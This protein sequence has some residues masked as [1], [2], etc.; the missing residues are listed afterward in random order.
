MSKKKP[1]EFRLED[2]MRRLNEIVETLDAE[3]VALDESIA[4]YEESIGIVESCL[5]ELANARSKI[6]AL[7]RRA[8][9][10]FELHDFDHEA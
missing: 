9:D 4:L 6:V 5:A 7:R 3:R 8:D 2:G 10:A 1:P